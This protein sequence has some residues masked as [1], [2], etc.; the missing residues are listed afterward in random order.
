MFKQDVD[1]NFYP[2]QNYSQMQ[3]EYENVGQIT[4]EMLGEID[5]NEKVITRKINEQSLRFMSAT[6]WYHNDLHAYIEV[7]KN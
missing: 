1:K 5:E 7:K 2:F 3:K 6:I 4:K